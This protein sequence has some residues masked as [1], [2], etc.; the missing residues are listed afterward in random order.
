MSPSI[1]C[2][3]PVVY[4]VSSFSYEFIHDFLWYV[5]TY[6]RTAHS[7]YLLQRIFQVIWNIIYALETKQKNREFKES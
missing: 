3:F 7:Q 5:S 2:S 4:G 1:L 6:A